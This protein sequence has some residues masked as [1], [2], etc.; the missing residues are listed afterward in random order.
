MILNSKSRELTNDTNF[1]DVIQI[2]PELIDMLK[3]A[4]IYPK[5]ETAGHK[6]FRQNLFSIARF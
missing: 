3:M 5:I 1:Q 6:K 2:R 4:Q